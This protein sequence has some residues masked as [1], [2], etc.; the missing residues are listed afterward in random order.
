MSPELWENQ[1]QARA[2]LLSAWKLGAGGRHHK[3][4]PDF[5]L[6]RAIQGYYNV[7]KED[8]DKNVLLFME[9]MLRSILKEVGDGAQPG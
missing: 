8:T 4:N 6:C 1:R 3:V 7:R 5:L 9:D 2:C